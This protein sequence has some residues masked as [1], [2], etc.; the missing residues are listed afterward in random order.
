MGEVHWK[1]RPKVSV[2]VA[3]WN[4]AEIIQEHIASFLKLRYFPKE[5]VLCAGGD[6]GTFGLAYQ[7]TGEQVTVIKQNL[8]EGKQKALRKTLAL[9]DGEIILLTD[10][11]CLFAD[12]SFEKV[13]APVV[14]EDEVVAT[15]TIQPLSQQRSSPFVLHHWFNEIWAIV[16]TSQRRRYVTGVMGAN[17]AI[18]RDALEKVGGFEMPVPSGTDYHLAKV[19]LERGYRIRYVPESAVYTLYADSLASYCHQQSRWLRNVVMHGLRFGA[20]DEVVQGLLPSLLGMVMLMGSSLVLGAGIFRG[21]RQRFPWMRTLRVLCGLAWIH[22]LLR[23]LRYIRFAEQFTDERFPKVGYIYL[24]FYILV[25]FAV[26]S[27]ALVQYPFK[28]R[29]LRW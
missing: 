21:V 1:F 9:A 19:L 17:T 16:H 12:E 23:R 25:D 6:D 27:W 26:W 3:A 4:E 20:Y 22:V 7:Y 5:L 15:G 10:A 28:S 8:G 29:R 11:D 13:L 14:N 18:R 24:P 2:L